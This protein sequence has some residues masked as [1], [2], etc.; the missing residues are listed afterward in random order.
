MSQLA[1]R[2]IRARLNDDLSI[3]PVDLDI[4]LQPASLD[5]RLSSEDMLIMAG[6]E[7]PCIDP[8]TVQSQNQSLRVTP[9]DTFVLPPQR[10]VLASTKEK[11]SLPNDLV[12][13]VEGRSSVGRM[14][15]LVHVT[16]GYIDP[17]FEGAITLELFNLH[18]HT[19][20]EIPTGMRIAQLTFT[21]LQ[22]AA[23][24]TYDGKYQH[25]D[26]PTASRIEEDIES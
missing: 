24:Q 18:Q 26:G 9:N 20:V 12:A 1:D 7:Y 15:L 19:P 6:D 17:G 11:V 22:C 10:V 25:Q 8:Q 3:E 5:V 2:D 4:Q 21:E 23:E 16:A 13:H 14:G